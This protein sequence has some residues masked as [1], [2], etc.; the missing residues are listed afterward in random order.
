MRSIWSTPMRGTDVDLTL[1]GRP[2]GADAAAGAPPA[3]AAALAGIRVVDLTQFEAGTS[4][5]ETLAWLG[6]DVI[7]VEPPG[8]GEQGRTAH[9][10]Q[11]IRSTSCCS[12]PTSAASPAT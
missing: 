11:A 8:K 5:T 1:P 10:R 12:T 7:K 3:S 4:C 6:A 9:D 2:V